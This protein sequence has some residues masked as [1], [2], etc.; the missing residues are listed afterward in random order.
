MYRAFIL[1]FCWVIPVHLLNAG[2]LHPIIAS[3]TVQRPSLDEI[4][5]IE[6]Q[7]K[8]PSGAASIR[9]YVRY[10]YT[11]STQNPRTIGGMYV[12]KGDLA[13]APLPAEEIVVVDSSADIPAPWDAGCEVV[14]IRYVPGRAPS[15]DASCDSTLTVESPSPEG[16]FI[17]FVAVTVILGIP[18]AGFIWLWRRLVARRAQKSRDNT[19]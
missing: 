4:R 3:G 14:T 1:V 7:V 6:A 16:R 18:L 5:L 9:E 13:A 17:E 10:Y 2:A 11:I 19:A 15:V 8:M 12:A